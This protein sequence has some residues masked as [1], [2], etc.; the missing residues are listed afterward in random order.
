[1]KKVKSNHTVFELK[2]TM[3]PQMTFQKTT[4]QMKGEPQPP[5]IAFVMTDDTQEEPQEIVTSI[6]INE[7]KQMVKGLET[8]ISEV[9]PLFRAEKKFEKKLIEW[10]QEKELEHHLSEH[11]EFATEAKAFEHKQSEKSKEAMRIE[12]KKTDEAIAEI[13]EKAKKR[14]RNNSLKAIQKMFNN[15]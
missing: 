1:M 3:E 5:E 15:L 8:I 10:Y 6:S 4:P 9:D 12:L 13:Y 11:P 14:Q 2:T 7:A